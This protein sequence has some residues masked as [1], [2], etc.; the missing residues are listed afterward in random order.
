[1]YVVQCCSALNHFDYIGREKLQGS[2]GSNKAAARHLSAL[3]QFVMR[4]KCEQMIMREKS[5]ILIRNRTK[6]RTKASPNKLDI[7]GLRRLDPNRF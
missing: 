5:S 7:S 3:C 1:M 2:E 6:R 4:K